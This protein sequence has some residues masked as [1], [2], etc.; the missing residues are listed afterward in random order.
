MLLVEELDRFPPGILPLVTTY[1]AYGIVPD[2]SKLLVDYEYMVALG[3]WTLGSRDSSGQLKLLFRASRDGRLTE[4]FHSRCDGKGPTLTIM[5]AQGT[6]N[7][8]GGF[9]T[10]SW[11]SE[12]G[13][14]EIEKGEVCWEYSLLNNSTNPSRPVRFL[15]SSARLGIHNST[16]QN[17][18]P[19]YGNI[20][21]FGSNWLL[22]SAAANGT[23]RAGPDAGY[24]AATNITGLPS[25]W[26]VEELE[27]FELTPD[28]GSTIDREVLPHGPSGVPYSPIS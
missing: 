24:F 17:D 28:P 15:Y 12:G 26:A 18:G 1:L 14:R 19:M 7:L 10:L 5:K 8:F 4:E 27:V 23:G 2:D 21:V 16:T 6:P 22:C 11:A 9:T 20:Q 3:A 13:W 25:S